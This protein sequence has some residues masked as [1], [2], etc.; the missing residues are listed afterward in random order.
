[1]CRGASDSGHIL[2]DHGVQG[3]LHSC[4]GIFSKWE[5]N[6]TGLATAAPR[7][8]AKKKKQQQIFKFKS[9]IGFLQEKYTESTFICVNSSRS[10]SFDCQENVNIDSL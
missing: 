10:H 2:S 7:L 8:P 1:M 5:Q 4:S 6:T 9:L 3:W